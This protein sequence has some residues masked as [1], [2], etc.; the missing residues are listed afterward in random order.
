MRL[1]LSRRQPRSASSAR[2]PRHTLGLA[3]LACLALASSLGGGIA[4]AP[5]AAA[6]PPGNKDVTATLFQWSF[7]SVAKACTDTLG[8]KGY[9]YV[10]VS[11]AQE[12]IQ[13]SQWWTS[14]QPVS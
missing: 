2:V 11:P 10:E 4:G 7:A 8:P 14:Y 3:A 12:H 13:G 9:G 1:A 6:T 5:T